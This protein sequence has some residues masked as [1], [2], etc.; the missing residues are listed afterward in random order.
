MARGSDVV[1][2]LTTAPDEPLMGTQTIS[3]ALKDD[4]VNA[5]WAEYMAPIMKVD[6]DTQRGFPFLLPLQWHMD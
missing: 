6:I 1:G 5:R 4:P 3:R 2:D